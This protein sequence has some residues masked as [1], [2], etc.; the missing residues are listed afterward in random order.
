MSDKIKQ[1]LEADA[2]RIKQEPDAI[3]SAIPVAAIDD[4]RAMQDAFEQVYEALESYSCP[5]DCWADSIAGDGSKFCHNE[6]RGRECG[7]VG[8][9]ALTLAAPYR[10]GGV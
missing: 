9:D 10:K 3:F 5:K 6:C 4:I 7:K 1:F 2:L 8:R